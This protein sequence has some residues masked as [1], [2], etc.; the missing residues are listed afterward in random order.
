MLGSG[1]HYD[2][3]HKTHSHDGTLYELDIKVDKDNLLCIEFFLDARNVMFTNA[4]KRVLGKIPNV[5][6]AV[7]GR[8]K[9]IQTIIEHPKFKERIKQLYQY[10]KEL[11]RQEWEST[12]QK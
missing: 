1:F 3:K 8:Y 9:A 2:I 5:Y 6:S 12:S 10:K 7:T 4:K 11:N